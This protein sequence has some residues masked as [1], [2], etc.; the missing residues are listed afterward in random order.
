MPALG[1]H[2]F[3]FVPDIDGLVFTIDEL[4]FSNLLQ[5]HPG[6]AAGLLRAAGATLPLGDGC[7][8][9]AAA[10]LPEEAGASGAWRR[11]ALDAALL[12]LAVALARSLPAAAPA[13]RPAS[14][15]PA[16]MRACEFQLRRRA[17]L[18]RRARGHAGTRRFRP[19]TGWL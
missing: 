6:L 8:A 19:V 14:A 3:P 15:V 9:A 10:A 12:R 5:P 2:G 18:H 4:H 16:G 1:A 11:A 7:A 13:D 17:A